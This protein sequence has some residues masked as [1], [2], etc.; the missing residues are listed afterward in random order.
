MEQSI[1]N[2]G[3]AVESYAKGVAS[4]VATVAVP[5]TAYGLTLKISAEADLD[6]AVLIAY[7]AAKIGGVV[8]AEVA[9]FLELA[10][11]ST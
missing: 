10:L 5:Q 6:S 3:N 1:G 7:L 9:A 4:A 11:K 8:P 2:V